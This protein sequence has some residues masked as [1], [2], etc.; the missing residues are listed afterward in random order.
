M[1]TGTSLAMLNFMSSI[2]D[3]IFSIPGQSIFHTPNN[4][5]DMNDMMNI[6]NHCLNW[7]R[8]TF[9]NNSPIVSY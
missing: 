3:G 9:M 8:N 7:E 4:M 2:E 6:L 1:M 5:F